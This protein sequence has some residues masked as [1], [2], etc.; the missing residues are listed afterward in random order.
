MIAGQPETLTGIRN[1]AL[2][3][4]GYDLLASRSELVGLKTTDIQ[5]TNCGTL[6]VTIR[7]SKTDQY[8]RGRL[9]LGS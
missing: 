3:S 6:K 5:F 8:G 4:L 2:F 7:K 1:R 9:A